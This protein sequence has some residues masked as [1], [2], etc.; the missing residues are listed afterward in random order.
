MVG[1]L[2]MFVMLY[3]FC[4][5]LI[6]TLNASDLIKV[7]FLVNCLTVVGLISRKNIRKNKTIQKKQ[8]KRT[9]P[10][11]SALFHARCQIYQL[12]G[13]TKVANLTIDKLSTASLNLSFQFRA[14]H[15]GILNFFNTKIVFPFFIKL[16]AYFCTSPN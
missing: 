1:Y 3:L 16:I 6:N 14:G 12:I 10:R 4:K 2:F 7:Y 5:L 11:A 9:S 13:L 8:T 15:F